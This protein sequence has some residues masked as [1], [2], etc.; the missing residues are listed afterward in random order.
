LSGKIIEYDSLIFKPK[1][2]YL[3]NTAI[4]I[5]S[6]NQQYKN[7][8]NQYT[9]LLSDSRYELRLTNDYDYNS[10]NL[11][12]QNLR[13]N[14]YNTKQVS[15]LWG[16]NSLYPIARIYNAVLMSTAYTSFEGDDASWNYLLGGINSDARTG[17]KGYIGQINKTNLPLGNYTIS[18]WAKGAGTIVINGESKLISNTWELYKWQVENINS[19]SFNTNSST[20]DELRLYPNSAQMTSYTYKAL[21]GLSSITDEKD[22]TN[23]YFYD[24][25]NRL[26]YI[27]DHNNNLIK[28]LDYRYI[29]T[30]V[31]P[32][33]SPE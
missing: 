8:N 5:S 6:L 13:S 12:A 29:T 14:I 26:N 22:L 9:T 21:V 28:K 18:L 7:N 25:Y 1:R 11:I 3:L 24:D 19:I 23:F 30:S 32:T 4:P 17:N 33:P 20:I 2:E 16:Y 15:Y 31:R 27:K 10:G